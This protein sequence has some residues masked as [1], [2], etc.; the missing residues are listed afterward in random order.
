FF[1]SCDCDLS[2]P[3][4]T[5]RTCL[6]CCK[7]GSASRTARRHSRVSFQA[8]T[9]RR[10][11]SAATVSGT[12]RTGR[13]ARSTITPGSSSPSLRLRP[14][15]RRSAARASRKR[16]SPG[17]S[18]ALRHSI[19]LSER[20]WAR[21]AFPLLSKRAIT[22]WA[23]YSLDSL[24]PT[25]PAMKAGHSAQP[26]TPIRVAWKRSA[27]PIAS[28]TLCSELRSTSTCTIIVENDIACSGLWRSRKRTDR[29]S[30]SRGGHWSHEPCSASPPPAAVPRS[31]YVE[32]LLLLA[33]QRGVKRVERRPQGLHGLRHYLEPVV[34]HL[35]FGFRRRWHFRLARRRHRRDRLARGRL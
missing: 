24:S 34:H 30:R 13:P 15:M 21:N 25:S 7:N 9:T 11:G 1:F 18:S 5:S 26:A 27:R 32:A 31:E 8:T 28:S 19:C 17:Y 4:S 3:I 16:S 10:S 14:M 20:P 33:I 22:F 12:S 6:A 23:S 29:P 35:Q 2:S